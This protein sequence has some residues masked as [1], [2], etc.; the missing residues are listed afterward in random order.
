MNK[1]N[2]LNY[3][4]I[5]ETVVLL[6]PLTISVAVFLTIMP[7]LLKESVVP[8]DF[9]AFYTGAKIINSKEYKTT[10]L[11]NPQI[12]RIVQE[13]ITKTPLEGHFAY[14][15]PPILA[16]ALSPFADL[17]TWNGSN[18]RILWTRL[19]PEQ[20]HR[21]HPADRKRDNCHAYLLSHAFNSTRL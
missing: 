13:G 3:R 16:F 7:S 18:R 14:L 21:H 17:D 1:L 20:C 4:Q 2:R 12:Q 19:R 9:L 10:D 11:Y 6:I 5:I 15:N 8:A